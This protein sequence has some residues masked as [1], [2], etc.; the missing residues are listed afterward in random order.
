MTRQGV[1]DRSWQGKELRITHHKARSKDHPWHG[2]QLRIT[3]DKQGGDDN[4]D[5]ARVK[6]N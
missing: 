2:K 4:H 6:D 3:H 5:K 1:D